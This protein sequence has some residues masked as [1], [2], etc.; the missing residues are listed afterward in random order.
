MVKQL[1]QMADAMEAM[2]DAVG[3]AEA[4]MPTADR[5]DQLGL[6]VRSRKT[7]G[8]MGIHFLIELT[9]KTADDLLEWRDCGAT[10]VNEIREMLSSR[11]LSFKGELP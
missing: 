5:V 9:E 2:A 10:S 6:S 1:R 4:M 3:E 8:R 11:G 7:L